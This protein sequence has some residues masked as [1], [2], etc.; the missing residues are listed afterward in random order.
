MGISFSWSDVSDMLGVSRMT[1]YRYRIDCN[2]VS[3]THQTL[4]DHQLG[5]IITELRSEVLYHLLEKPCMVMGHLQ[6]HG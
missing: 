5:A 4:T 1:I 6:A 3:E 2:M